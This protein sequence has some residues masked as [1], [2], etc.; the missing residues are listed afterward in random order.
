VLIATPANR[1]TLSVSSDLNQNSEKPK[2]RFLHFYRKIW[3]KTPVKTVVKNVRNIKFKTA[4]DSFLK[5]A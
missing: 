3:V 4:A 1:P 2:Y 5:P